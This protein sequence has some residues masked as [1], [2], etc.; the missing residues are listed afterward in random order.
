MDRDY[1]D[2]D[3]FHVLMGVVGNLS[4]SYAGEDYPLPYGGNLFIPAAIQQI[5]IQ[6]KGSCLEV[7]I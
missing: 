6:G 5:N 2:Q 1:E 4:V 3:S 7:F